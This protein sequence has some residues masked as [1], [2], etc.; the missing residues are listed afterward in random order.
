MRVIKMLGWRRWGM[1]ERQN[2][3]GEGEKMGRFWNGYIG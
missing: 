1:W 3:K 2:Y